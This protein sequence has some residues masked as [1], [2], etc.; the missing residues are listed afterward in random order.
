MS[1]NQHQVEE[2]VNCMQQ[3]KWNMIQLQKTMDDVKCKDEEVPGS[4]RLC[5]EGHEQIPNSTTEDSITALPHHWHSNLH[6]I[7]HATASSLLYGHDFIG[8]GRR[9]VNEEHPLWRCEST[10]NALQVRV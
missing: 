2:L 3:L 5:G 9:R 7:E 4:G 1:A 6:G 8:Q 10:C